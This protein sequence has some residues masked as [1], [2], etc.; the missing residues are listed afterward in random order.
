MNKPL[1]NENFF[2]FVVDVTIMTTAFHKGYYEFRLCEN[3]V[4]QKGSDN[5][6]A[7]TIDCLNQNLLTSGETGDTK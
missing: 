7:V 5:S 3:N 1:N 6:I 2:I 4:P